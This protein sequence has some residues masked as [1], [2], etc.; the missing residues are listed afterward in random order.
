MRTNRRMAPKNIRLWWLWLPKG[1]ANKGKENYQLKEA[2]SLRHTYPIQALSKH[3]TLPKIS[4]CNL[5]EWIESVNLE[6]APQ[7]T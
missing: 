5:Y 2:L 1:E 7:T 3:K 6:L 4:P